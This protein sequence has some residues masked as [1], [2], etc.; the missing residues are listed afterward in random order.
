MALKS[1]FLKSLVVLLSGTVIAQLLNLAFIPILSRVYTPEE[2][3]VLNFY[4]QIVTFIT[5]IVTLRLELSLPLEKHENHRYVLFRYA[6]RWTILLSIITFLPIIIVL[7]INDFSYVFNWLLI[8]I[9]FGVL[10]HALFNL[11][12]YWQLG[13]GGFSRISYAKLTRSISINGL[14]LGFGWMNWGPIGL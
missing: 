14:K 5:A 1:D 11:G 3:G 2:F 7:A 12:M 4:I 13:R 10:L 9:P 8:L 6:L